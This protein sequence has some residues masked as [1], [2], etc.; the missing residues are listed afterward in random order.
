MPTPSTPWYQAPPRNRMS[1][2]TPARP[3]SRFDLESGSSARARTQRAPAPPWPGAT[4]RV[5]SFLTRRR[6]FGASNVQGFEIGDALLGEF[7]VLFD[8]V[9]FNT[10]DFGGV[11][12]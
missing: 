1:A 11:E 12:S 10:A 8:E 3:A 9:V 7:P 5:P 2:R 4:A 6:S